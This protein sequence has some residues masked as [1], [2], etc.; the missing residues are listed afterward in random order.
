[1]PAPKSRWFWPLAALLLLA[2]CGTKQL[3]VEELGVE[4]LPREVLGDAVRLTLTYNPGAAFSV[5]LGDY[6]RVVFSVLA[7]VIVA[8]LVRLY[9]DA[10]AHDRGLGAALG[11]IVGGA[12]GNLV[13]RVR[14]P[15]GVVDFIDLGYGDYRFWTF[16]VADVGVTVGA[17]LMLVIMLRRSREAG[18]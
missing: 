9:R 18:G 2:D 15:R 1:M 12:V 10:E 17:A 5:S 16:N 11:M 4:H 14:S 8:V 3:A 7:L 13:D 6:S